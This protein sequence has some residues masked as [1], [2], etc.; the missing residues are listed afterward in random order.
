MPHACGAIN[1]IFVLSFKILV[2]LPFN[3]IFVLQLY[4]GSIWVSAIWKRTSLNVYKHC[5]GS[6][7]ISLKHREDWWVMR[8]HSNIL[9][10][11]AFKFPPGI[12]KT[13]IFLIQQW[14]LYIFLWFSMTQQT[15]KETTHEN[16]FA[17]KRLDLLAQVLVGELGILLRVK[18]HIPAVVVCKLT[19]CKF[20]AAR[21]RKYTRNI[22]QFK[23]PNVTV[24]LGHNHYCV[25]VWPLSNCLPNMF[26][27]F[28]LQYIT[29]TAWHLSHT[30]FCRSTDCQIM[31]LCFWDKE[32][33]LEPECQQNT[34][35]YVRQ[36]KMFGIHFE[37][38]YIGLPNL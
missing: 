38:S 32:K 30:Q 7:G 25:R 33:D 20:R 35:C 5:G 8:K 31:L 21:S 11:H 13:S 9:H 12:P 34:Q 22:L 10:E 29:K 17:E 16:G 27:Y 28:Y 23:T 36:L 37:M 1:R 26:T 24:C 6:K 3:R 14:N 15:R 18:R 2:Y 4:I 19:T